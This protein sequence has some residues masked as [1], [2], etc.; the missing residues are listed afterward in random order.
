MILIQRGKEPESLLRYRKSN[1]EA[2]YEEL[3]AEPREDIRKQMWLEQK[4]LCAYC[5]CK[6][7]SSEDVRIEHYRAR[8]PEDGEYDAASTLDYKNML[9]V[10]YGNSLQPGMKEEDKTCDAHRRNKP[11][12]VNPYDP[13][14]IRKIHYTLE[15]YIASCDGNIDAD[16]KKTLNLN[17]KSRSLPENRKEVLIRVKKEIKKICE[18]KDHQYFLKVLEK[19]YKRYTEQKMLIPYCGIV[20]AWLEEKL[21]IR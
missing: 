18:G 6:L 2:C 5:M 3:P 8:N 16:V 10:C 20:I 21:E 11:L 12:T 14:S 19:C 13:T 15:G 9:G 17:C 4:G 1:P 7:N